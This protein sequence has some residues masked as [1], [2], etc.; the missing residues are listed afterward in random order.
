MV[1]KKKNTA[2]DNLV[3]VKS[4]QRMRSR[5]MKFCVHGGLGDTLNKQCLGAEWLSRGIA[6]LF[7]HHIKRTSGEILKFYP[8]V[9]F[10][11]IFLDSSVSSCM[12]SCV[13]CNRVS[14]ISGGQLE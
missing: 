13:W 10:V 12:V 8:P 3:M 5:R 7:L 14:R 1:K 2:R 9:Q 11:S 6:C 4:V